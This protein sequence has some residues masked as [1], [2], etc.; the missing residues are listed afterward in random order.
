MP[1]S[2]G[3]PLLEF[4]RATGR[5]VEIAAEGPVPEVSVRVI[6]EAKKVRPD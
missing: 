1:A 4:Y 3:G 5:L 6:A 2:V